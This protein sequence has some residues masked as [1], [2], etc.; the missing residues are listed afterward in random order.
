MDNNEYKE[1]KDY[2]ADIELTFNN[3]KIFNEKSTVYHKD[4]VR[5]LRMFKRLKEK[6]IN[7]HAQGKDVLEIIPN[8]KKK[9]VPSTPSTPGTPLEPLKKKPLYT[10]LREL[11][12]SL[13]REDKK[14]LFLYPVDTT[15]VTDYLTIVS[16]PMDFT[17]M[18]NK[19][20]NKEYKSL[21]QFKADFELI[22]KN[23]MKYNKPFTVYHKEADRLL[24]VGNQLI[25][26][27]A[28]QIDDELETTTSSGYKR[29]LSELFEDEKSLQNGHYSDHDRKRRKFKGIIQKKSLDLTKEHGKL[30]NLKRVTSPPP[31]PP[32]P[33]RNNRV[34]LFPHHMRHSGQLPKIIK[35]F[36]ESVKQLSE[37][38]F[39]KIQ[40]SSIGTFYAQLRE[41]R[42]R[43]KITEQKYVDSLQTFVNKIG[44]GVHG[45]VTCILRQHGIVTGLRELLKPA[46][47]TPIPQTISTTNNKPNEQNKE[48]VVDL[49][50]LLDVKAGNDILKDIESVN[51][52]DLDTKNIDAEFQ[53]CL[54]N[55]A[56]DSFLDENKLAV[57]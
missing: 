44:N 53:K 57:N 8:R 5:L 32:L 9:E 34:P 30:D 42:K 6:V 4:A 35:K 55:G 22:C 3:A 43:E 40:N 36:T 16:T 7:F 25:D 29:S 38:E 23:A 19:L 2:E 50:K 31:T 39:R 17:T 27:M 37:A 10:V 28:N 41:P 1:W 54:K 51:T 21:Q 48:T 15:A 26:S 45:Q 11:L 18:R 52:N 46:I 24:R 47:L 49:I 56:V 33:Q 12:N 20:R 14:K 13:T